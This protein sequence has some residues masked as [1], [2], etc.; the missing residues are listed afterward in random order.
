[1]AFLL[2]SPLVT[3]H[4][5]QPSLCSFC[6]LT[7]WASLGLWFAKAPYPLEE[8]F[9]I[10]LPLLTFSGTQ[11]PISV[12]WETYHG[13]VRPWTISRGLFLDP[14]SQWTGE[15]AEAGPTDMKLGCGWIKLLGGGCDR[16]KSN[17]SHL[18][19]L[20]PTWQHNTDF[21]NLCFRV[22]LTFWLWLPLFEPY[23]PH[24]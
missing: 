2:S 16:R 13:P 21:K 5:P 11:F 19:I 4:L 15:E 10:L 20:F 3:V 23:F 22:R 6:F 24:L 7:T 14:F 17:S 12:F 18:L 8:F 9:A 1:M